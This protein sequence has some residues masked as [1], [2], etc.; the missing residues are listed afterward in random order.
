MLAIAER[1]LPRYAPQLRDDLWLQEELDYLWVNHFADVPRVNQV[2][3]SFMGAWKTRLGLITLSE[4]ERT[5]YIGLNSLLRLPDV[6][7]YVASIT[8]AHEM[9]HYCHG[10]GSPLPRQFK[11]PHRG[12]IVEKELKRRGLGAEYEIYEDWVY[13]HWYDFYARITGRC[14]RSH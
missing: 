11:Y 6:P 4:D 8:L 7:Y 9:V 14:R 3:V 1:A 5:T 12:G 2:N 13:T 10:F